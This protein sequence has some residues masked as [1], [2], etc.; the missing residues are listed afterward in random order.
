MNP[1]TDLANAIAALKLKGARFASVRDG[2]EIHQRGRPV[3]LLT[4]PAVQQFAHER[5]EA[6]AND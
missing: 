2:T 3:L 6:E 4:W 1:V 5:E